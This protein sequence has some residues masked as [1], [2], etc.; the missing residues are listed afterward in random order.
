MFT[1]VTPCR[2][3][4]PERGC[5]KPG[6][7]RPGSRSRCRSARARGRRRGS[8]VDVGRG[9]EVEAGVAVVLRG[10]QREPGIEPADRDAHGASYAALREVVR[11]R[12]ASAGVLRRVEHDLVP[13][14]GMVDDE[15][16]RARVERRHLRRA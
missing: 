6:V 5:T 2:S 8:S 12:A 3:A 4:S 1:T 10:G 14:L 13:V 9:V 11:G 15:L 16:H 7:A